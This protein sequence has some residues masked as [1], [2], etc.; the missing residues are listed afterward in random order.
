MQGASIEAPKVAA[1]QS[2]FY[3][4]GDGTL[5]GIGSIPGYLTSSA[6]VRLASNVI[7]V[8][9]G[10]G[11]HI[12]YVTGDGTLYGM[13]SNDLGQLGNGTNTTSNT[14][15]QI[16]SD[17][18]AV[19]A[20]HYHSL[21]VK[22]DGTLWGMGENLEGQLGDG[23][24][25]NRKVPVFVA[26]NVAAMAAGIN[27][28]LFVTN[29]GKL[30]AM[31]SNKWG[32][33][34]TGSTTWDRRTPVQV[35]SNVIAVAAGITHSLF[36]TNDGTLYGMGYNS[37]GELGNHNDIEQ[38][39]PVPVASDV[40]KVAAGSNFT[41][42]LKNDGS[43][44]TMGSNIN[45]QLGDGALSG[46]D[47]SIPK[48]IAANVI[49]VAAS[50]YGGL[51][52]TNDGKLY[53]MGLNSNSRL[54]DTGNISESVPVLIASDLLSNTAPLIKAQPAN[55][56]VNAGQEATLSISVIGNPM[57][58]MQWQSSSNGS[59]WTNLSNGASYSGV[60]TSAL[61][62][63]KVTA[64]MNGTRY[65]CMATNA[66]GNVRS[67]TALLTV[68]AAPAPPVITTH[69]L[70]QSVIVGQDVIFIVAATSNPAPTYQWQSSS[71]GTT[72][73]N[74]AGASAASLTLRS[75]TLGM[76]GMQYRCRASNSEGADISNAATLTVTPD[77]E[78]LA[79]QQLK[80]QLESSGTAS[81]TLT[82]TTDLSL[83][84]GATLASGK[85]ITGAGATATIIG[86]LTIHATAGNLTI[87]GVNIVNGGL[88]IVGARDVSV[89][90]CTFTD[91]PIT[92]TGGADNISF[93]WNRFVA[94]T[95][96]SGSG[97]TIS[98]AGASTGIILDNNFWGGGLR[99]NMPSASN[100]RVLIRNNYFVPDG[101]GNITATIAGSGAQIL[102]QN[103]IY[104]GVHNP[105]IKQSG[106]LIRSIDNFMTATTGTTA[107][108]TDHVF[109]PDFSYLIRP[110]GLDIPG[111]AELVQ[112]ISAH[113]GNTAGK[114]SIT[115]SQTNA[116]SKIVATMI[117]AGATANATAANIPST[118]N[119]TLT[120]TAS[121]FS[122][123]SYQWYLDNFAI[124]EATAATYNITNASAAEHAGVYAVA[125]ATPASEIVTSA[126][127]TVSVGT[128]SAPIITAHPS[129]QT[130]S[131]GQS[132]SFTV[133]AAGN[134][135]VYQWIKD[136]QDIVGA[137]AAT[138]TIASTQQ[139]H[140]G[141]YSAR[142]SNSVG[143]VTSNTATLT[144][145]TSNDANS[146]S[147]GGSSSGGGGGATSLPVFVL[148][149][150]LLVL[151]L[152][153]E[154]G[155]I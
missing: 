105:L 15:V 114:N 52:V 91:A 32:K 145:N 97:M 142:V 51:F 75:V 100:A 140:A 5:Y 95:A 86:S 58:E 141:K 11:G 14:P 154:R 99:N 64:A 34:G 98:N 136:G 62:I 68:N 126:G 79:A 113:A 1:G 147:G 148:I 46:R 74:I 85:T 101:T 18:I 149:A 82:G 87:L 57:P 117:G 119:L 39:A 26:S 92:I 56:T 8:A 3:V 144:V 153:R 132:A 121:G 108:G 152:W 45:G 125:L 42:F 88:N 151:R 47:R 35:A 94:T 129:S 135:L 30:Y 107:P 93:F 38:H 131:A 130:A 143:S 124:S 118:G 80:I 78:T 89:T 109:V 123:A 66:L 76:N 112:L 84:G 137:T 2:N 29:D 24:A 71:N 122:P 49:A 37:Y 27:H 90:H 4:T 134:M 31:G 44:Y 55:I 16:A 128:L 106:G 77:A 61:R 72:W 67:A 111:A 7:A 133:S 120:A 150:G 9:A 155:R 41:I 43:L 139:T 138:Y 96:G 115:P 70:S 10:N 54:G 6:P 50:L 127:F 102:S 21:F 65:S 81:I 110:S 60:T 83:V 59:T 116:A 73:T 103:N 146:N 48:P 12:L 33:L 69:P 53:G 23:T 36:V 28:S 40:I 17:V 63:S 25:I 22:N 104:Q 19:A 13:G 20:G